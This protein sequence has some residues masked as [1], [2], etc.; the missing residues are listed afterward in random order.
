N[1]SYMHYVPQRMVG[2]A[3][4][5]R[6]FSAVNTVWPFLIEDITR[7]QYDQICSSD[8][9]PSPILMAQLNLVFAIA[10]QFYETEAGAPLPD[11]YAAGKDYYLRGHGFVIAH[12]FD[13][14]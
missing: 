12:A 6:Y 8:V 2:K 7:Q 3:L 9:P 13:T 14:C 11:V 1:Q 10:C 5:D 4:L